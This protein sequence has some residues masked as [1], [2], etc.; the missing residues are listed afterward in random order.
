MSYVELHAHSNYSLL[1]GACFPEQLVEAAHARGMEAIALTDHN[2]LY[3]V[4]QFHRSARAAGIKPIIGAELTLENACHIT[5]LAK[6]QTGYSNLSRLITKAQ[7]SG[8]KGNPNLDFALVAELAEG[9][10]C[11]SGCRKGEIGTLLLQGK[12]GDAER[13]ARKYLSAFSLGNFYIELQHHLNPEDQSLCR[14]LADLAKRIGVLSVATNNV[15]YTE[16]P[17]HRLHDVLMCIRNRVSL[18]ESSP[19]R[20]SNSE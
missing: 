9:L 14:H 19:F 11:L 15:H 20:R 7:L 10:I 13:T 4:P 5:L 1:D 18:D 8:A 6:N 12:K 16:R 2:G 17:G 3:G